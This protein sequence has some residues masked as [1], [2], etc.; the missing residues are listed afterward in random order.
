MSI[1]LIW[2]PSPET[3]VDVLIMIHDW[4]IDTTIPSGLLTAF[5]CAKLPSNRC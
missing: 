4:N 3:S 1:E 2:V 5:L